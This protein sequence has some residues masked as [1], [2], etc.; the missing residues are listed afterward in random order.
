MRFLPFIFEDNLKISWQSSIRQCVVRTLPFMKCPTIANGQTCLFYYLFASVSS[1]SSQYLLASQ[2]SVRMLVTDQALV[3]LMLP[4]IARQLLP[5]LYNAPNAYN[6]HLRAK[7]WWP[8]FPWTSPLHQRKKE[9][10]AC[11]MVSHFLTD[12]YFL[13]SQVQEPL[14]GPIRSTKLTRRSRLKRSQCCN[15]KLKHQSKQ[16]VSPTTSPSWLLKLQ[17]TFPLNR[18]QCLHIC[19][20]WRS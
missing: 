5:H 16:P 13:V 10:K 18:V 3:R 20:L 9:L 15:F 12:S 14:C 2:C 17:M 8:C 4:S 7:T 19:S 6:V 11:S 1:S